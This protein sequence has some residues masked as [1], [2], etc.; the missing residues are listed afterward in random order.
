MGVRE[1]G[2]KVR[3]EPAASPRL[4]EAPSDRAAGLTIRLSEIARWMGVAQAE[5]LRL[6]DAGVLPACV[7]SKGL[8]FDPIELERRI[9]TE[10]SEEPL[11]L[12]GEAMRE[13]A[14]S[15]ASVKEVSDL[16]RRALPQLMD[17]AGARS[18]AAFV[19]DADAWLEL[20]FAI[21]VDGPGRMQALHGV[22]AW[23]AI[24]RRAVCLGVPLDGE[25]S[26][27]QKAPR[28]VLG[29]PVLMAGR[30]HGVVVL[31][32][33]RSSDFLGSDHL[34]GVEA[35][36]SQLAVAVDRLEARKYLEQGMATTE[37]NQR[38]MEAFARD[39]RST[40]TAEKQR[41][42]Q[43]AAALQELEATYLATVQG[44]AVA[45][46]AKDEYTAG[47]L[48][49]VTRY[50]MAM[51]RIIAPEEAL[52][53]QYEY[54]FLLHDVG[55]MATPDS[56][57]KKE[58]PLT[59]E[60]WVVMRGHAEMGRRILQDIPFLAGAREI[61]FAH[62]ERWDGGGYPRG[63]K[64]EE[65]PLGARVFSIADSFDAM[66]SDRPYRKALPLEVA[67]AEI[68]KGSGTQFW[69]PAVA[70]FSKIPTDELEAVAAQ[71]TPLPR[72]A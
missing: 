44:L 67:I 35:V 71:L 36:A 50:G 8:V 59:D 24:N 20:L 6:A 2:W 16:Y 54:G 52:D 31:E 5:I 58:G 37:L 33:L 38:Q 26:L 27:T 34:A 61:V 40:F 41:A 17:L 9:V 48:Q 72:T 19:A 56:V 68:E 32:D 45:V 22:A 43:L 1:A 60:E 65:I 3:R 46:E 64:G 4:K 53:P 29:V 13:I 25:S 69:P 66:R 12:S 11:V 10:G 49:R 51:M 23:V 42:E 14:V 62:H 18:A 47:H 30:L 55:K 28:A 57:L 21:E 15:L 7:G 39:V 70:A 63:L